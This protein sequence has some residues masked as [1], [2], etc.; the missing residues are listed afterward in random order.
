MSLFTVAPFL[1]SL[2]WQGHWVTDDWE[3]I[4]ARLE[5]WQVRAAVL[6]KDRQCG[7]CGLHRDR[8]C[9]CAWRGGGPQR[10][11]GVTLGP[12]VCLNPHS[13]GDARAIGRGSETKPLS[14]LAPVLDCLVPHW[15]IMQNA[16]RVNES[17]SLPSNILYNICIA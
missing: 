11:G 3:V 9:V 4:R 1:L 10:P 13:C 5:C 17:S 14:F 2:L 7:L 12:S 6:F 8:D 16:Y 15:D